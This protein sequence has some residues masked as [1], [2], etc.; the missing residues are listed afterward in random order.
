MSGITFISKSDIIITTND[1]RVRHLNL[2]DCIQKY[3]YKGHQNEN[4][5]IEASLSFD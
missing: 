3:K 1:S 2:E 4:L 5:Q